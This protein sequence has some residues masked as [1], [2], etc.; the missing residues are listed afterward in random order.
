MAPQP[1]IIIVDDH[2]LF[3]GAGYFPWVAEAINMTIQPSS[4]LYRY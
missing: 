3:Y 2:A 1:K 4:F